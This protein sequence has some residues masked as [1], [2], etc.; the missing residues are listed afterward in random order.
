MAVTPR[1]VKNK[2]DHNGKLTGR[3]GTVYDVNIKYKTPFGEKKAY[4]KK[5]FIT[6]QEAIMHEAEM[7]VKLQNPNYAEVVQTQNNQTIKEYLESWINTR[8]QDLRPSTIHNYT[9]ILNSYIIPN[10]G[11][12]KLQQLSPGILDNLFKKF[13]DRGLSNGTVLCVKRFLSVSLESAR[14]YRLTD[15]NAAK[16]TIIKLPEKQVNV[17]QPYDLEQ[18]K[19]LLDTVANT[20][21]LMPVVL[22]GL[23]GLRRSE[24][25]GLRWSLV[26]LNND[27]F[28]VNEQLPFKLSPKIKEVDE[29]APTKSKASDRI[30]PITEYAKPFFLIQ[31]EIQNLQKQYAL[32]NGLPYY[33][34]GLVVA[35]QDGTPILADWISTRFPDLIEQLNL[36]EL[37]FHDLR[38]TAATNMYNL[39]G[40]FFTVG[41]ILGHTRI[42]DSLGVATSQEMVTARYVE[43]RLE[44]KR[45]VLNTYHNE[46]ADKG[47]KELLVVNK[48]KVPT[49]KKKNYRGY[50]L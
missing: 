32:E 35:K 27:R 18:T 37:R 13:L 29:M 7:K 24:V 47:L 9:N 26:D 16:D 8:T 34:N 50:E 36:P 33:D 4:G 45:D 42:G 38:H 21:W 17:K 25:V 31:K 23:Y 48:A 12:L 28:V 22:G 14:K 46:L 2:R 11:N 49:P 19:T 41:E 43:V 10:I 15:I 3:A 6:K 40:D 30:L 1:Q 20:V 39:T 44:R 5:G